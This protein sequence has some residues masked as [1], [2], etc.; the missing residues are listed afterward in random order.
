M[1][2]T[3]IEWCDSTLNPVVG[4]T[5]GC[6]YCYARKIN[7]RFKWIKNFNKPQFFPER[8]EQL[9][10]KKSKIIFM[11]SMSDIADWEDEW[12]IETFKAIGNNPQ[13]RYLFL[14][15]RIDKYMEKALR[16]KNIRNA[17]LA[18]SP[19]YYFGHTIDTQIRLNKLK[20]DV[21][22][23]SVEPIL[24]PIEFYQDD[25]VYSQWV[26]I[27]AETGNRKEKIIPE[28]EWI[29]DIVKKCRENNCPV[30]MKES[31]V[32]IMGEKNMLREFPE[33]LRRLKI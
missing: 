21:D 22:F 24:E 12:I 13:H 2:K 17:M 15:K 33:S 30:F 26:I 25:L 7:D 9:K 27:G 16:T 29:D 11:N 20:Y 8:L 10:S 28:K 1:N 4:C 5:C 3:K 18:L 6:E 14:T 23:Y 32:P 19:L 31:L